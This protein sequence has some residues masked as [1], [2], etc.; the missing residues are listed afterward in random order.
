MSDSY[1]VTDNRTG[2][3]VEIPIVDGGISARPLRD[4]DPN[5]FIYDP[6]FLQTAAWRGPADVMHLMSLISPVDKDL[7]VVYS[8]L[9]PVPFRELLVERRVT[10]VDPVV[11]LRSE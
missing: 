2:K 5:V 8:P 10:L 11:A 6:A 4:L 7:V 9:L 3:S 1:T